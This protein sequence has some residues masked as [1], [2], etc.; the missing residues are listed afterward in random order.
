MA[1]FV[2][3][4]KSLCWNPNAQSNGI[5]WGLWVALDHEGRAFMNGISAFIKEAP[6]EL[7]CLFSPGRTQKAVSQ[8]SVIQK[9]KESLTQPG[10]HP[11]LRLWAINFCCL[12][13]TKS[14]VF[15]YSGPNRPSNPDEHRWTCF[16]FNNKK[17]WTWCKLE[18]KI[19]TFDYRKCLFWHTQH[20]STFS[21][22]WR[23][24]NDHY[25]AILLGSGENC[26]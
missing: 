20:L 8:Q 7:P 15:C 13:A 4:P 11:D 25:L 16:S 24:L 2:F 26:T 10:W 9:R 6:R 18:P 3:L 21:F 19:S 22:I 23:T 5:R 17:A 12:Q 1:C 14:T